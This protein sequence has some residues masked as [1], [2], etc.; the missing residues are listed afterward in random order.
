VDTLTN[1]NR[2]IVEKIR[3]LKEFCTEENTPRLLQAE[4]Q[5]LKE[6]LEDE[7]QFHLHRIEKDKHEV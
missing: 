1:Q 4:N 3:Q 2:E 7:V 5:R 6:D